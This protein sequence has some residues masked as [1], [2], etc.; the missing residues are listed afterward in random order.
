MKITKQIHAIKVPFIVTND[1]G[2][3]IE[4]FVYSYVVKGDEICIIDCGISG[5]DKIYLNIWK[6][7]E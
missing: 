1:K 2:M 5:S 4:R 6:I 7:L 3:D